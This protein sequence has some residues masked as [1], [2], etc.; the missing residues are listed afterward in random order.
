MCSEVK[1]NVCSPERSVGQV[2]RPTATTLNFGPEHSH[3]L[4]LQAYLLLRYLLVVFVLST[5]LHS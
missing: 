5:A 2:A 4:G 1:R 3:L